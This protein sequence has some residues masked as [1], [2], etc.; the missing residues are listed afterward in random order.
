MIS[1][2]VLIY[3]AYGYKTIT[4][5]EDWRNNMSLYKSGILT[6][7]NSARAHYIYAAEIVANI[8][9]DNNIPDKDKM[10]E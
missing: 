5:N 2:F 8:E 7:P 10:N 3:F 1:L 4:R 6:S 9:A